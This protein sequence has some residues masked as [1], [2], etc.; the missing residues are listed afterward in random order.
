MK[1]LNGF[2]T[3]L[4]KETGLELFKKFKVFFCFS[5]FDNM[6]NFAA[7]SIPEE[8]IR[9]CEF[10]WETYQKEDVDIN[11]SLMRWKYKV[12]ESKGDII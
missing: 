3:F 2:I 5:D 10:L 12:E 6:M 1:S 11:T 7:Q 9:C 8:D 4:R